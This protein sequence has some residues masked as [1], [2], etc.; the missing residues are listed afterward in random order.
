MLGSGAMGVVYEAI[1]DD[2][3]RPA[4]IKLVSPKA[5]SPLRQR[6]LLREAQA[7]ARLAHPNVVAV[8]ESSTVGDDVFIAMELVDGPSLAAWLAE[9]RRGWRSILRVFLQA[10]RG[11]AAAHAVDLVHRDFKPANVLIGEDGRVRVADFG[12]A[13][14]LERSESDAAL[15]S[16]LSE[17]MTQTG[18]LIGT[19]AYMAPELFEGAPADP[20]SDQFSFCAA[21]YEALYGERPFTGGDP[22]SLLEDIRSRDLRSRPRGRSIP[23]WIHRSIIRGLGP[24]AGR[25]PSMEALLAALDPDRRR[26]RRWGGALAL[27]LAAGAGATAFLLTRPDPSICSGGEVLAQAWAPAVR[28]DLRATLSG[29]AL[30]QPELTAASTLARLDRYADSWQ[31]ARREACEATRVREEQSEALMDARMRCLRGRAQ[32]FAALVGVL[33]EGDLEVGRQATSAVAALPSL[34]RC[35][36]VDYVTAEFQPPETPAQAAAIEAAREA[37]AAVL[38]LDRAGRFAEALQAL[39]QGPAELAA[40][41]EYRPVIA[42]VALTRGTILDDL[43]RAEEAV[44]ALERAY[45]TADACGAFATAQAAALRLVHIIGYRQGKADDAERWARLA[46]AKI[47]YTG[48]E[49]ARAKL[50]LNRGEALEASGEL[51]RAHAAYARALGLHR[52]SPAPAPLLMAE[53]LDSLGLVEASLGRYDAATD[54]LGEALTIWTDELGPSHPLTARGL[55]SNGNLF[56]STGRHLDAARAYEGALAIWI[57]SKGPESDDV[58]AMHNNLAVVYKLAGDLDRSRENVQRALAIREA[59]LGPDHPNVAKVLGN[60]GSLALRQG[61]HA[62]AREAYARALRIYED[63]GGEEDDVRIATVLHGLG[64]SL[65]NLGRA[66]EAL[67]HLRRCIAARERILP[68]GHSQTTHA[69]STLVEALVGAGALK[70][71]RALMERTLDPPR[72]PD[73]QAE[74]AGRAGANGCITGLTLARLLLAEGDRAGARR[75]AAAG[76]VDCRAHDPENEPRITDLES[77]LAAHP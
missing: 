25:W 71:A 7:M 70:D 30:P 56:I 38:A 75:A 31:A 64:M 43:G 27:T 48:D 18:A 72:E 58:A 1:D 49:P 6:R 5:R 8:Y 53:I 11:V 67:P 52:R 4:A 26:R 32:E 17:A 77:W 68:A 2:L 14:P 47:D 3:Q 65:L 28:D 63:R 41:T 39:D 57:D 33:G 13:R 55:N 62:A 34:S 60:L 15:P 46:E 23:G 29:L 20:L 61:D 44:Q 74:Q 9:S 37:L 69:R 36:D 12:L 42:E 22:K 66:D 24:R 73:E 16:P 40:A 19:P 35:A 59:N 21:L 10:G 50:A 45:V 51:E 54:H 76:L